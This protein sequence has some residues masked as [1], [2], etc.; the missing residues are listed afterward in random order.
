MTLEQFITPNA[1]P[2]YNML[3]PWYLMCSYAYYELDAPL[4][5]DAMYDQMGKELLHNWSEIEHYHKHLIT[6]NMLEAGSY[7][8]DYPS[9]VIGAV[10]EVY[11]DRVGIQKFAKKVSETVKNSKNSL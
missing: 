4:V 10:S 2:S 3:I 6:T 5:S 9:I 8:G 11:K 7:I 1:K